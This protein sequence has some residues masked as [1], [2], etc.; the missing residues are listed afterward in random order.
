MKTRNGLSL[1]LVVLLAGSAHAFD[2]FGGR[3]SIGGGYG[4]VKPKLPYSFQDSYQDGEA[5]SGHIQYFL[6]NDVSV[7]ASYADLEPYAR[8]NKADQ[9]RFRPI[10]GSLRYNIFHHLPFTPYLTAGA[11]YS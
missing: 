8:G 11:G 4:R 9:F 3:L 2:W 1:L 10:V 6:N 7:L 5:W